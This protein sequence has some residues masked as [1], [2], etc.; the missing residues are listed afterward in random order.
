MA[1]K[2][3]QV[4]AN[5]IISFIQSQI[6][7][8][9]NELYIQE[10]ILKDFKKDAQLIN[11]S[12][13]EQN[14]MTKFNELDQNKLDVQLEERSLKWLLDY[15]NNNI[16]DLDALSGYFGNLKFNNFAPYF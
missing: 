2:E 6:D 3:N 14:L 11:P 16:E 7:S 13:A 12:I 9:E 10:N 5:S 8:L 4:S 1:W 15:A